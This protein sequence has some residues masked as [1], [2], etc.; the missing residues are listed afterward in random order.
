MTTS[1]LRLRLLG[2]LDLQA[3]DG[4]E[5]RS[6]L[7]QPRRLALLAYLALATPRGPHRRD[8]LLAL[9]WPD[10]DQ[11]HARNALSQAVF[12]LRSAL[13]ADAVVSRTADE[14]ALDLSTVWCDAIAFDEAVD[15]RRYMDAIE[16]YRGDLLAG[17]HV[18]GAAPE[19]SEWL[20]A[21]RATYARRYAGAMQSIAVEREA[22]GDRAGA[23]VW[24]RRVA[25]QDPLNSDAA[26][27][28][29]RALAAAGDPGAAIRHARVHETLLREELDA[30][31]DGRIGQFVKT[32]QGSPAT[33]VA[34]A[35]A[36]S[37]ASEQSVPASTGPPPGSQ[38]SSRSEKASKPA[39]NRRASWRYAGGT[40]VGLVGAALAMFAFTHKAAPNVT[41]S[42]VAVIPLANYSGD[43]SQD[44]L[45]DA[46]TDALITELARYQRLSVISRTSVTQYKA[47]RKPLPEIGRELGCNTVVEGS[48][49]RGGNRVIV[50]AQLVNAL[51]DRHLWAERYEREAAD[52]PALERDIAEAV[53]L[54]LRATDVRDDA[55]PGGTLPRALTRRVDPIVY[56]LYLRGRDAALSRNPAGLRLAIALYKEAIRRDSSLALGYAGLADAYRL[57][58]GFG[59]MPEEFALDS[60]P[61]MARAALALDGN[62]SEAHTSMAG[63][64]TDAGDWPAAEREFR[65]ALQLAPSNALAHHWY[66][67]LLITL[68]RKQEALREI[69]R[70]RELDPLSQ[71]IREMTTMLEVYVGIRSSTAPP[72]PRSAIVDPNH[73][74]TA[75]D[76]SVNLARAGRCSEAVAENKRAQQ[77]APDENLMLISLVGVSLLCG[78]P[79][80]AKSLLAKVERRPQIELQGVYVAEIHIKLGQIDSAFAWLSR[81]QWG[82]ANRMHLRIDDELKPL[83]A[84]PRFRQ[85]LRKQNMP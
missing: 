55:A 4:S 5:L 25:A 17:F 32:L 63:T 75:A 82:M 21:M 76:R 22:A 23:V 38:I 16:L 58:G 36:S 79:A 81:T 84:D 18:A 14:V 72:L 49:V 85:L 12:F 83:R 61:V 57:A 64:L 56:G 52:L 15:A 39:R 37:P 67:A 1:I 24:R 59:Y 70:A 66:A 42:C 20:D 41:S 27:Q 8:R 65:R 9:F 43:R 60:A 3:P 11:A 71:A 51:A 13:G 26:L 40:A 44:D 6:V 77:L 73:P 78:D 68:D 19:F 33:T 74:G 62:L 31:P 46:V 45:A 80:G 69:R 2:A 28:L 29:M 30:P 48:I 35:P 53:A 7:A 47:T 34:S 10:Q 54:Q 50:D